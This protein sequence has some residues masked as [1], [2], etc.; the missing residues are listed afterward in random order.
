MNHICMLFKCLY[1]LYKQPYQNSVEPS[2]DSSP[3]RPRSPNLLNEYRI[4]GFLQ[5]ELYWSSHQPST[6]QLPTT[7]PSATNRRPSTGDKRR[8]S[9]AQRRP[10]LQSLLKQAPGLFAPSLPPWP[11]PARPSCSCVK[12]PVASHERVPNVAYLGT[13]QYVVDLAPA[14]DAGSSEI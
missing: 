13:S 1:V 12:S 10:S 8:L 5:L 6:H 4:A 9:Y 11:G 14:F 2:S 7:N 3:P